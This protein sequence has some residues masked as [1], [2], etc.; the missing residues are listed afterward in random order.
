MALA[1]IMREAI[2][3]LPQV[4]T[5]LGQDGEFYA[6]DPNLKDIIHIADTIKNNFSIAKKDYSLPKSDIVNIVERV[7]YELLRK[8]A[9]KPV[10][11]DLIIRDIHAIRVKDENQ[12][13]KELTS[14]G[15]SLQSEYRYLGSPEECVMKGLY[16]WYACSTMKK[17]CRR[18]EIHGLEPQNRLEIHDL[19]VESKKIFFN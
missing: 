14:L 3:S 6:E 1:E 13:E 18:K 16:M 2:N 8:E 10:W 5:Y 9:E 19:L 7:E 17:L 4:S 11:R 12:L 15:K